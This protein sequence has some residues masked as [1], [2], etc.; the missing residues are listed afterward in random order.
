VLVPPL[1]AERLDADV[2]LTT[3]QVVRGCCRISTPR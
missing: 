1:L 3:A 2:W